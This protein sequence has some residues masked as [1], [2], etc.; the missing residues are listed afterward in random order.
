MRPFLA[1][2]VNLCKIKDHIILILLNT[3]VNDGSRFRPFE[4]FWH[5][6][7]RFR[8]LNPAERTP[9][10][11]RNCLWASRDEIWRTRNGPKGGNWGW[12]RGSGPRG[13]AQALEDKLRSRGLQELIPRKMR[14]GKREIWKKSH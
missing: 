3:I 10:D 5:Y 7:S 11:P 13:A 1:V 14:L 6:F 12:F 9:R 2:Y 8:E 4:Q